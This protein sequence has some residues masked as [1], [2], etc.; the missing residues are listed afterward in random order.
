MA[1]WMEA[2]SLTVRGELR[3]GKARLTRTILGQPRLYQRPPSLLSHLPVRSQSIVCLPALD[4]LLSLGAE[5][6]IDVEWFRGAPLLGVIK[7]EVEHCLKAT[8]LC[9]ALVYSL[10]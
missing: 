3:S 7:P 4:G 1:R 10:L 8:Y 6:T 2:W 5:E 9:V